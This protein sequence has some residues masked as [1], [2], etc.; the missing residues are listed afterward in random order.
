MT[1]FPKLSC[2]AVDFLNGRFSVL[3]TYYLLLRVRQL[4][5]KTERDSI[6]L[7]LLLVSRSV[8]CITITAAVI[9]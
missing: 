3:K 8:L 9:L 7:I 6:L 5:F 4:G 1:P 2:S